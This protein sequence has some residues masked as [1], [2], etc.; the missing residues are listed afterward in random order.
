MNRYITTLAL[1][2]TSTRAL[3]LQE[4]DTLM[5]D[6]QAKEY[7][8]DNY[9]TI[10]EWYS[11]KGRTWPECRAEC[12]YPQ[13]CFM[14]RSYNCTPFWVNYTADEEKYYESDELACYW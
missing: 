7:S 9:D 8:Q 13:C 6:K 3:T 12:C 11:Q 5:T 1:V 2:A 4:N 14:S 10:G